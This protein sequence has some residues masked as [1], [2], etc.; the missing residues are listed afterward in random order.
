MSNSNLADRYAKTLLAMCE[1]ENLLNAVHQDFV[2]LT[3]ILESN[4]EFIQFLSNPTI[5]LQQKSKVLQKAF[6]GNLSGLSYRFINF[7][8]SKNRIS[9]LKNI[10]DSFVAMV[11]DK[12]GKGKGLVYSAIALDEGQ[13]ARIQ[14]AFQKKSGKV[15][16]FENKVHKS[17]VGGFKIQ[18]DDL[19]YDWSIETKLKNLKRQMLAN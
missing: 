17:L 5:K 9:Y 16:T 1:K 19:V 6:E 10:S 12:L 13:L 11:D 8:I 4:L 2:A 7:L 18:I 15:Y 14:S 3:E